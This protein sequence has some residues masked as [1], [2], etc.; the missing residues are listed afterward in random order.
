MSQSRSPAATEAGRDNAPRADTAISLRGLHQAFGPDAVALD[1]VDLDI[2]AGSFFTLLGPSG[3]G[4]T[5]L[6][7]VIAG[8][9]SPDAGTLSIGGR[10][11]TR[12]AA[13]KRNVNTVFQS[14]ALFGHLDVAANIGFG[15]RM[16]GHDRATI[17]K[18]VAETAAFIQIDNLLGRRIDQLSGGQRQRVALAR[19]LVNEPDVLLLDEP[20]SALDAGLRATLQLELL[21]IQRRLGMTF[22]FV[23][24]DQDEAMV[25]SDTVAVLNQGRIEQVGAPAALYERPANPFVA[26]FMG[27]SNLF[28]I[29]AQDAEGLTAD[30]GRLAGDFRPGS[31]VLLRPEVMHIRPADAP[32][33]GGQGPNVIRA[34]VRERL[35]RGSRMEYTVAAGETTLVAVDDN[36]GQGMYDIGAEVAL[37]VEQSGVV[38]LDG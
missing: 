15:L 8:L 37:A 30:F 22:V 17:K 23:T 9:D 26:R 2:P 33:A 11:V 14:Y 21:R 7:R 36:R 27:H 12:T 3:C 16:Q 24:H 13:H 38:T 5:S 35:Y 1:G 31:H 4:K 19:A 6:L 10:D 18:R 25:M 34:Q 32:A 28:A 29:R 20:L